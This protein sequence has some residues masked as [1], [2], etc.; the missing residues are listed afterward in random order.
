MTIAL[1]RVISEI[2]LTSLALTLTLILTT[3]SLALTFVD[4]VVKQ[5]SA[6]VLIALL[7]R[8]NFFH[9]RQLQWRSRRHSF[10]L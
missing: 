3:T 9:L 5:P 7:V 8:I 2:L 4:D 10:D 6:Q 1:V